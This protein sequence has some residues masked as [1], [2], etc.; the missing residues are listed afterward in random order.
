M[1]YSKVKTPVNTRVFRLRRGWD[2]NP[3]RGYPPYS[4]SRGAPSATRPPLPNSNFDTLS[5]QLSI[6]PEKKMDFYF[7]SLFTQ[8]QRQEQ[9]LMHPSHLRLQMILHGPPAQIGSIHLTHLNE[10][11]TLFDRLYFF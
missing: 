2:S 11:L 8:W 6:N 5:Y 4:L 10:H 3:R 1:S 9:R 7:Y